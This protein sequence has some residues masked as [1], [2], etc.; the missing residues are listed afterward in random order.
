MAGFCATFTR[1]KLFPLLYPQNRNEKEIEVVINS[2]PIGLVQSAERTPPWILINFFGFWRYSGYEDHVVR[3]TC[4]HPEMALFSMSI[5]LRGF[6][7]ST[8][9]QYASSQTLVR[10]CSTEKLPI[11][12]L[13]TNSCPFLFS[14]GH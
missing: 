4:F 2:H 14:D 1:N 9:D 10:P 13:E 3:L 11:S 7:S 12:K 5:V 8:Y 6:T